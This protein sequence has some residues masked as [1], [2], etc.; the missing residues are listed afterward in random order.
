MKYILIAFLFL[1]VFL[2]GQIITEIK[3]ITGR[4]LTINAIQNQIL[5]NY[6]ERIKRIEKTIDW[7][8][9]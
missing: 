6:L 4:N 1:I 9:T 7:I 5:K 2:Q 3:K 8:K